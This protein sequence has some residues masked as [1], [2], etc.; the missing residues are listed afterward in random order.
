MRGPVEA[1]GAQG[2]LGGGQAGDGGQN[3]VQDEFAVFVVLGKNT[4]KKTLGKGR[5]LTKY[6]TF[7]AIRAASRRAY[8]FLFCFLSRFSV[9]SIK[10]TILPQSV[11]EERKPLIILLRAIPPDF[12]RL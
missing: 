2:V 12:K 3:V 9:L 4:W 11:E 10:G 1:E 7:N 5:R 6:M 8:S